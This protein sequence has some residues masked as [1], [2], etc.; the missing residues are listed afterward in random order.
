MGDGN[1]FH[2][3]LIAP[4]EERLLAIQRG[5]TVL[6]VAC[7]NTQFARRLTDLGARVVAVDVSPRMIDIAKANRAAVSG[8]RVSRD[9]RDGLCGA[10][11]AGRRTLRRCRMHDGDHGHRQPRA[12]RV[13][14]RATAAKTR[15][16]VF[17]V[18]HPC[19][20]SGRV[21]LLAEETADQSGRLV[22]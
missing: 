22:T 4:A 12:A 10:P 13:S 6:D 15:T 21:S 17:S 2:L 3:Q 11:V 14:A 19:F 1:D 5:E 7:G 20:N 16:F 8:H 9:R 18:V